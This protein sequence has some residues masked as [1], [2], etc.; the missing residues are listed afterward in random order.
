MNEKIAGWLVAGRY[1]LMLL[2]L[3]LVFASGFGLTRL[4][5]ESDY[6]FF[7]EDD[8][9][10]LVAYENQ[11]DEYTRSENIMFLVV[12]EKGTIFQR[13]VLKMLEELTAAAWRM[14]GVLRVDSLP[15][16]QWTQPD[17]DDLVV[18]PLFERPAEMSDSDIAARREFALNSPE[19]RNLLVSEEMGATAV[20]VRVSLTK[21][22]P[23]CDSPNA[24]CESVDGMVLS[25]ERTEISQTVMQDARRLQ[26]RFEKTYPVKIHLLGSVAFDVTFSEN[27]DRDMGRLIPLMLLVV[28]IL[29]FWF[30]RSI[31]ATLLTLLTLGLSIAVL[32]GSAGW[33]GYTLNTITSAAPIV[34]ITLA[35]CDCVHL[36]HGYF[37]GLGLGQNR[38]EA[39]HHSLEINLQPI[40]LTSLTT[41]IGFLALN[42]SES[43]PFRALGTISA[44]GVMAACFISLFL[45]PALA[46]LL[47]FKA[48]NAPAVS[49]I[50]FGPVV[51]LVQERSGWVV[52]VALGVALSMIAL[53]PLNTLSDSGKRYFEVGNDL[54]TG[55]D[56]LDERLSGV[57][58]SGYSLDTGVTDGVNSPEFLHKVDDFVA[59]LREQPEVA[60]A[61][62][63]VDVLKRINRDLHD[64]NS[65]Y[66]R[67][68]ESREEAAQY[69]LLYELSLPQGLDLN[70]LVNQDK[71][72]LKVSVNVRDVI[73]RDL[74]LFE[75]R[76]QD[77]MVR[78]IP[79]LQAAGAGV[80]MMFGDIGQRNIL[81]MIKGSA[82][83][84]LF[85]AIALMFFLRSWKFGLLSMVP[86]AF[87]CLMALGLWA[88]M[89]GIVNLAVTTVFSITLGL[90]VD[91]TV[92]FLSKYLRATREQ[93][94]S[95]KD[96]VAYSFDAVGGPLVVTTVAL[97]TGFAMLTL[98]DFA[99]F[100]SMGMLVSMTIVIA[101]VFDMLFLPALLVLLDER[102]A[103][104]A[105][106]L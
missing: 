102:K 3:L 12:P 91:N 40:F 2:T 5:E 37:K 64:G 74:L 67:V 22:R 29:V 20:N 104:G 78:N 7:F 54:R 46:T 15:N 38:L 88:L 1:P 50:K 63:Y 79:E 41:A 24:G 49:G 47:P 43:P 76:V 6:K 94:L 99:I 81:S 103:R 45:L 77:Y 58:D 73:S 57:S 34:I 82:L 98:S 9:P 83:A 25:N 53:V 60:Y 68:P 97:A 51:R 17:G 87:P 95:V 39:I 85:I 59:W 30:V 31:M 52:A 89:D 18:E 44:I 35:V 23:R 96:A 13:D 42:F 106:S 101:L 61:G 69:Q 92:H 32:M 86:N 16:F 21:P 90:V 36:F 71:S 27:S 72:A 28:L 56:L 26:Q 70:S 19:L 105:S 80:D 4:H 100:T 14:S 66:F 84:I 55:L 65:S 62:S 10:T 8:D 33:M 75:G 48:N 93:G 11:Q